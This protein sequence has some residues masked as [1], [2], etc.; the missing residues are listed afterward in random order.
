MTRVD[1]FSK[2]FLL[3]VLCLLVKLS[4]VATLGKVLSLSHLI[5]VTANF[6]PFHLPHSFLTF[7]S[8]TNLSLSLILSALSPCSCKTERFS[9]LDPKAVPVFLALIFQIPPPP[10]ILLLPLVPALFSR[11]GKEYSNSF[12]SFN[13]LKLQREIIVED[14]LT[15]PRTDAG[16]ALSKLE[17]QAA[18]ARMIEHRWITSLEHEREHGIIN[19]ITPNRDF[20]PHLWSSST[21]KPERALLTRSSSTRQPAAIFLIS[22]RV[23]SGSA[24][25]KS[26]G[27]CT[28]V[29]MMPMSRC[30]L[31]LQ[32]CFRSVAMNYWERGIPVVSEAWLRDSIKKQEAQP[33]DAYDVVSDLSMEGKGI[34]WDKQ[35]PSEEAL[36]SLSAEVCD[37]SNCIKKI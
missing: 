20:E 6:R 3:R 27:R 29:D 37:P 31:V 24:R 21:P 33:L 15:K 7:L 4:V 13:R 12:G 11:D 10:S 35:D 28:L 26:P 19:K 25:V 34:P 5:N 9:I 8:P 16:S 23:W 2:S 30:F 36:E 32:R 1:R 14:I 18:N 22:L 17:N